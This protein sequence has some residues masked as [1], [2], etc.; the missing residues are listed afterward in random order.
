MKAAGV[1]VCG[2]NPGIACILGT[3]SNSIF[4]D[5]ENWHDSKVGIGYV[6]GDEG[7]GAFLG[8]HLL[9]DF[10]YGTLPPELEQYLKETCRLDKD[11]ILEN[12]YKKPSPN[13]YLAGFAP[14]LSEFRHT[15]YVQQ[16]L[17]FSFTEFFKYGVTTYKNYQNYPVGFVG[18][19]AKH[20][21]EELNRVADEFGCR[22]GKFVQR[23]IDDIAEYFIS[24]M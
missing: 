19:I 13:R 4:F 21:E 17:H 9:R 2:G 20:F 11:V 5:G 12:V 7:S 23:P 22:L 8:K 10:I 3:G 18:S 1:A 6:L 24:K 16:L 15:P 14:V